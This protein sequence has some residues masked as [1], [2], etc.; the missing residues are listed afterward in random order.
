MWPSNEAVATY[1]EFEGVTGICAC[2]GV[3]GDE[4]ALERIEG[5]FA[6]ELVGASAAAAVRLT[7][8]RRDGHGGGN[9]D[10][11]MAVTDAEWA[12]YTLSG[13]KDGIE[14]IFFCTLVLRSGGQWKLRTI[15]PL[16]VPIIYLYISMLFIIIRLPRS[17]ARRNN[18]PSC[19]QQP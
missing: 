16:C 17:F 5:A 9:G 7:T 10:T 2:R 1:I 6:G 15:F 19:L 12:W 3:L 11:D 18:A 14:R 13:L 8:S 4:V